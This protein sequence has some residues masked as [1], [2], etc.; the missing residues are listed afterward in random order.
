[1]AGWGVEGWG[2]YFNEAG[3]RRTLMWSQTHEKDPSFPAEGALGEK[4][5]QKEACGCSVITTQGWQE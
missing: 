4:P 5:L 2:H 3:Q 1:M